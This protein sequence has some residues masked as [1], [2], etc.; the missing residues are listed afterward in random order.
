MGAHL[1]MP[2]LGEP[3]EPS[4]VE[5]IDPWWRLAPPIEAPAK[6]EPPEPAAPDEIDATVPWP[7]D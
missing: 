4:R 6:A 2:R 7:I 3:V 5:R 1:V